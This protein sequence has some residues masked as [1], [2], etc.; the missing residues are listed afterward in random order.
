M[1]LSQTPTTPLARV[2]VYQGLKTIALGASPVGTRYAASQS[3]FTIRILDAK[4]RTFSLTLKGHPQP[5]FALA[6]NKTGTQVISGDD[7]ARIYVWDAKT[8][9][10]LREFP[11]TSQTHQRGIASLSFSPDGK[12][13]MSVGKD[14]A[15]IFWDYATAKPLRKV[16][17]KG[18]VITSGHFTNAKTLISGTLTEGLHIRQYPSLTVETRKSVHGGQGIQ[19]LAVNK[20]GTRA[21]SAGRDGKISF[22]NTTTG[23][24]LKTNPAHQFWV[25]KVAISP[26]GRFAASSSNDRMVKL[27]DAR[28][29]RELAKLDQQLAVGS[30]LAFS[31][32][33]R[34]LMTV[35]VFEQLQVFQIN[36][37]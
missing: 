15:I 23:A 24:I 9:A 31:S 11:R 21:V 4:T 30:P 36:A 19:D 12:T 20:L 7:S 33:G 22:W 16:S 27:W 14:D 34:F 3:D 10:K 29:Y 26:D 32:D 5:A 28:N 1:A 6:W 35:N 37:K 25:Q 17:G 2:Q 13:L 18:V 8:G